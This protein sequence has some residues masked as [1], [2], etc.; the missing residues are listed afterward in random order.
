MIFSHTVGGCYATTLGS[1]LHELGH[2]LGLAH[3]ADGIM[4][5]GFDDLDVFF[6]GDGGGNRRVVP[7]ATDKRC[8]RSSISGDMLAKDKGKKSGIDLLEDYRRKQRKARMEEACGG[9]FW[10]RSCALI[11]RHHR[12]EEYY[13]LLFTKK[14]NRMGFPFRWLKNCDTPAAIQV[15]EE[16][17][18]VW[19]SSP[20]SVIEFRSKRG[21]VL[22]HWESVSAEGKE[23]VKELSLSEVLKKE[24]LNLAGIVDEV[25]I[26]NMAGTFITQKL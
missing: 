12:C 6:A 2:C 20:I 13:L 4:S 16:D 14:R 3:T 17:M 11:L 23:A 1:L 7:S 9:A 15:N 8:L 25:F 22:H 19:S 18:M 5:R 21:F 26:I 24:D 10:S